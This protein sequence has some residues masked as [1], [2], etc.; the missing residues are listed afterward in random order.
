[1]NGFRHAHI[2]SPGVEDNDN[3]FQHKNHRSIKPNDNNY[4][5]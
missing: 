3:K 1:M 2:V 4:F 5:I